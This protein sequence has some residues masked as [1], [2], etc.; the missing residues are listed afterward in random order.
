M[1]YTIS[2]NHR[3]VRYGVMAILAVLLLCLS[4][5]V[6]AQAATTRTTVKSGYTWDAATGI[7]TVTSNAGT[8]AWQTA[9]KDKTAV[10]HIV[11][12]SGVTAIRDRA[13][14]NTGVTDVIFADTVGYIGSNAFRDCKSLVCIS[15]PYSI[16]TIADNAFRGSAVCSITLGDTYDVPNWLEEMIETQY[17]RSGILSYLIYV[18]TSAVDSFQDALDLA[19]AENDIVID[20]QPITASPYASTVALTDA[21]DAGYAAFNAG[22][23]AQ[24]V[25]ATTDGVVTVTTTQ[26]LS[27]DQQVYAALAARQDV[28]V[29]VHYTYHGTEHTCYIAP[30]A[31]AYFLYNGRDYVTF[32][33]LESKD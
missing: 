31:N 18:P 32:E 23:A 19:E 1:N 13:F 28:E 4:L 26:Y 9:I 10:R 2:H 5:A 11:I 25:G 27:F 21:D 22:V 3:T 8:T 30:Q 33:Y 14:A 15:I 6:P 29:V 16:T 12:A 20:V 17:D 7:L 24:I